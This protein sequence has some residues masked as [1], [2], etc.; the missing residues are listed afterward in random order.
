MVM[1]EDLNK[2]YP[3]MVAPHQMMLDYLISI[4]EITHYFET[5][6]SWFIKVIN[7]VGVTD[8]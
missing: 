6:T 2:L 5:N 4:Q 8:T 7:F 3:S 1:L